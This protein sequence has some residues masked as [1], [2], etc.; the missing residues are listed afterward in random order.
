MRRPTPRTAL[1]LLVLTLLG[2]AIGTS[3]QSTPSSTRAGEW[4]H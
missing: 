4:R 3:G 1:L 2:S